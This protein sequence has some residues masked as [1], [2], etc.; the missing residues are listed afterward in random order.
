[1]GAWRY[2]KIL[3]HLNVQKY[4]P[5]SQWGHSRMWWCL[6][7]GSSLYGENFS[8]DQLFFRVETT[9]E[10]IFQLLENIQVEDIWYTGWYGFPVGFQVVSSLKMC[11]WNQSFTTTWNDTCV[12]SGCMFFIVFLHVMQD[13]QYVMNEQL[14]TLHPSNLSIE[15][16]ST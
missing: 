10:L 5:W 7:L 16:N 15:C 6:K 3:A 8:C 13:S 11:K 14:Y 2:R 4:W 1:M 9:R 12:R